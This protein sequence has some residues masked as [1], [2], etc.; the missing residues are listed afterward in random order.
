M[1]LPVE[2]ESEERVKLSAAQMLLLS[3][4]SR[5]LVGEDEQLAVRIDMHG[6]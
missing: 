3:L 4:P 2:G 6:R 5:G 1:S